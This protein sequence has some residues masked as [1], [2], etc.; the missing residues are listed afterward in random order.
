MQTSA[1]T[2]SGF[3]STSPSAPAKKRTW[4]DILEMAVKILVPLG[5]TV[6]MLLWLTRHINLHEMDRIIRSECD[7]HWV[8]LMMVI[9]VMSRVTRGIRWGIQLRAA[10]LRR[11]PAM[12]EIVSIFGAYSLNLLV[13]YLGETWRCVYMARQED[14]RLSSVVGTDLGDRFSDAVVVVVLCVLALFVAHQP[15]MAFLDHYAVGRRMLH[16]LTDVWMWVGIVGG[17]GAFIAICLIFKKNRYVAKVD[18]VIVEMWRS[19]AVMFKMK[20]IGL[21]WVYTIFIW[22]CYFLETYIVFFAFPFTR[23]L[24]HM[25]GSAWGL[26]PGLVLFVFCSISIAIPSNGGLGPWNIALMSALSLYGISNTDGF[27]FSMVVWTFKAIMI[28]AMGIFAALWIL[29]QKRRTDVHGN[30]PGHFL[31]L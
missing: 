16:T 18:A 23:E 12:T 31:K 4:R 3:A 25:P 22:V 13:P 11:M 6:W 15:M 10:G 5:I 21:Y 20:G 8:A 9:V 1:S 2:P 17:I 19:F 24:I 30:L 29:F 27:A 26:A 14:A 7:F 28:I